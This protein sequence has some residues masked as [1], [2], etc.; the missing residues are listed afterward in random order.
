MRSFAQPA[1]RSMTKEWQEATNEYMKVGIFS[2]RPC[3]QWPTTI[4]NPNLPLGTKSGSV[5]RYRFR[6][7]F[8]QGLRAVPL[9]QPINQIGLLWSLDAT[10]YTGGCSYNASLERSLRG[11]RAMG[12]FR[13]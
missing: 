1:P 11:D 8:W 4:A 7:L 6:K 2:L 3:I 5:D 12:A 9:W 10:S 13:G